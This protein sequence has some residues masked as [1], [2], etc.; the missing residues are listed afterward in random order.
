MMHF[1]YE[2]AMLLTRVMAAALLFTGMTEPLRAEVADPYEAPRVM[3][4]DAIDG[5]D[6]QSIAVAVFRDGHIDW[7]E[8]FGLADREKG[9]QATPHTSYSVASISKPFTATGLMTLVA[10]G[11]VDLD[12][13][14]NA[15]LGAAK[16]RAWIGDV[17]DAT[18]RQVAVHRAG[19]PTHAQFF[20]QGS[21]EHKP[22]PDET[23]RRYGHIMSRPGERFLYSNLGYGLLGD[24]ISRRSGIGFAA[25]MN[26]AVFAP[27]DLKETAMG[28]PDR[29]GLAIAARYALSGERLPDYDT[30]HAGASEVYSSAHDLIRFAAFHLKMHLPEQ[31]PILSDAMIDRMHASAAE[32]ETE[33]GY[34]IGFGVSDRNGVRAVWH[35]GGMPGVATD[36]KMFPDQGIAIVVL[37]NTW[38]NSAVDRISD[39]IAVAIVSGWKSNPEPSTGHAAFVPLPALVGRWIGRVAGVDEADLP[40]TL[41]I[42]GDGRVDA[43]FGGRAPVALTKAAYAD[44]RLSGG[45]DGPLEIGKARQALLDAKLEG[46]RLYGALVVA[47][48]LQSPM[49]SGII[50]YWLD[51]S[52]AP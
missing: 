45:L 26:R 33:I 5:K 42:S 28:V 20:Y 2:D 39:G 32:R 1:S 21:P 52:R 30:S 18:V 49:P 29:P 41:T 14:A 50:S 35:N 7:E 6:V 8:G 19:L 22:A 43:V 44:G 11:K 24:I 38:S 36:L 10:R 51:L 12:R 9:I 3:I 13:P 31:K 37:S 17:R 47:D 23:I 27:L 34:G 15:Y 40:M 16:L 46:E 48:E 4:R 25:Y